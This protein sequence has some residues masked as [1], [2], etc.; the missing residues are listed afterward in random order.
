MEAMEDKSVNYT[1]F[2]RGMQLAV[3]FIAKKLDDDAVQVDLNNIESVATISA[4]NDNELG[5]TIAD[6]FKKA[7]EHGVVLMEKSQTADTYVSVTEG[8]ELE[9][10]YKSDVFVTDKE[11]NRAEYRDALVL[12]SNTK[13]ERL[14]QIEPFAEYAITN[15]LP[16]V[17]VAE[18]DDAVLAALAMNKI[19]GV[20]SSVVVEPSHFGVRRKDILNDLAIATGGRCIDED[21]GDNFDTLDWEILGRCRKVTIDKT[22]TV[23]FN[24]VTEEVEEHVSNLQKLLENEKNEREKEYIRERI[25]K[26]SS[27]VSVVFVGASSSTEQ[28][29]KADRVDDAIHATKAALA[30]GIV[31]GGGVALYNVVQFAEQPEPSE[32]RAVEAGWNCVMEAVVEP[33]KVILRNGDVEFDPAVFCARN[34]GINVKTREVGD[35]IEMQ[36][37][38]PVKVTKTALRN[39]VSAAATLLSTTTTI[40][41]LRKADV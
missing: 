8:F 24:E 35:M 36:I 41:N 34:I 2:N 17:V 7:G 22:K 13:I 16:L 28:S 3:E 18:A 20:L 33:L 31:A 37:I 10:G 11:T 19:K 38:D 29:E 26:I 12:I 21:T 39:G 6:A 1:D 32:N 25:A 40:V 27:A 15:H 30:E 5:R 9:K 4:N 14:D 23:F